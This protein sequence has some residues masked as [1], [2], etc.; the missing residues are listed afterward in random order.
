MG[1]WQD[2]VPWA[3][4]GRARPRQQ[5]RPAQIRPFC[6]LE[7]ICRIAEPT[8]TKRKRAS[9]TGP[10]VNGDFPFLELLEGALPMFFSYCAAFREVLREAG[11]PRQSRSGSGRLYWLRVLE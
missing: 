4:A 11:I 8:T 6:A 3:G 2:P 5:A 9:T 10:T 7:M 1:N